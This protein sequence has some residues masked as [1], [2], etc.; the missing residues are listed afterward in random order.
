VIVKSAEWALRDGGGEGAP[1]AIF[2]VECMA[3]H[4]E[5]MSVDNDRLAV[6]MWALKHTGMHPVHRLFKLKTESYWLT[7]PTPG[8]PHCAQES[9]HRCDENL[10]REV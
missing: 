1:Q 2:T 8:N 10:E 5:S 6:E 3:C 9:G 7:A 4:R